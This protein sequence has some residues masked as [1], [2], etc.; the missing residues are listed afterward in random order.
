MADLPPPTPAFAILLGTLRR[1][2]GVPAEHP[3]PRT[4]LH[5]GRQVRALARWHR[6]RGF[7][8]ADPETRAFLQLP[9]QPAEPARAAARGALLELAGILGQLDSSGVPVIPLKGP[10]LA[11]RLYGD[12]TLRGVRDLDLL[13]RKERLDDALTALGPEYRMEGWSR[14][15]REACENHELLRGSSTGRLVELHWQLLHP[16]SGFVAREEEYWQSTWAVTAAGV[17]HQTLDPAV[18]ATVIATHAAGHLGYRLHWVADVAALLLK[19]DW[20]VWERAL[21]LASR[22][23]V[24]RPFLTGLEAAGLT[25]DVPLPAPVA[26]AARRGSA[27]HVARWTA[28]RLRS[29]K[30]SMPSPL[31][32]WPRR[33]LILDGWR[34]RIR[35]AGTFIFTPRPEDRAATGLPRWA[36]PLTA[37]LRPVL[38]LVPDNRVRRPENP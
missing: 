9:G 3:D 26:A 8:E 27:R 31:Q 2:L 1:A 21:E 20:D 19:L 34:T 13:V 18:E 36:D 10:L 22:W 25:L 12:P 28:T 37:L 16:R 5:T 33:G 11:A 7:L 6:V 4:V 17:R 35:V 32:R 30:A 15:T 29:G 23:R 38:S 24:R 14:R